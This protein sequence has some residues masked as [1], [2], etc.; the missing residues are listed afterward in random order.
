MRART[1]LFVVVLLAA[2]MPACGGGDGNEEPA[3][4]G[5]GGTAGNA[6]TGS[7]GARGHDAST[8]GDNAGGSEAGTV[9]QGGTVGNL[10]PDRTTDWS[11]AGVVQPDGTRGI[12][13]RMTTCATVDAQYGDGKAD[14]TAAI[15]TAID[16]C[17]DGQVV[18]LPA[19]SYLLQGAIGIKHPVTLRGA[20]AS[21]TKI[22][23]SK[24]ISVSATPGTWPAQNTLHA[25][26]WS[27][28]YDKGTTT[29]TVSDS[30]W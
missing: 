5:A 8:V 3:N 24:S 14:A 17:P 6:S 12:P 7:G 16:S 21:A 4:A 19:G 22:V 13:S 26:D 11:H 28:G 20:G 23:A 9:T 10:F 27:A 29:I 1:S 18:M 2:C 15:Q 25:V 30:L